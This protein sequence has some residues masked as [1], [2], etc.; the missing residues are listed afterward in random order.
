MLNL[1]YCIDEN[2]N[3]QAYISIAS[4]LENTSQ[5]INVYIIHKSPTSF[6]E[7]RK[8]LIHSENLNNFSL[9]E[10]DKNKSGFP[11][12]HGSHVSDATYYRLFID[13]YLPSEIE[14]ILYV[15]AD[16]VCKKDI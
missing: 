12:V 7:Y 6:Q 8:K 2:Y 5:E 11:N 1:L 13:D 4:I 16:I 3:K 14:Y 15:D 9:F 10:F